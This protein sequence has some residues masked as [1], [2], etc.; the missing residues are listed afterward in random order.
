MSEFQQM[1]AP[2]ASEV[3]SGAIIVGA[4]LLI[5][6]ILRRLIDRLRDSN[7][8]A[9]LMARR[10]HT[11]RRWTLIVLTVLVLM[12][13]LGIF[14]SAWALISAGLAAVALGFVAAWSMLSNATAAL[15]ILTFRPFRVGDTVELIEPKGEGVGGTVIDMNLMFVTLHVAPVEGDKL[16]T[17][18]F[19]QIPNNLFFQKIVRTRSTHE[20]GS[21][22]SFF[23]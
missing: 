15:L 13:V 17:P 7:H 8:L 16:A 23:P 11:F 3:A 21:K 2:I 1:L 12:Q 6:I 19:L 18:Q 22:A 20:R 4:A 14:G 9:P 10:L 5:S